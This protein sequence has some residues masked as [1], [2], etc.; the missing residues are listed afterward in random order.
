MRHMKHYEIT[1]TLI[2]NTLEDKM[3]SQFH[4]IDDKPE[5]KDLKC[6]T[7]DIFICDSF[8]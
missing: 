1:L 8:F 2:K 5:F 3:L 6:V 7:C 4:S